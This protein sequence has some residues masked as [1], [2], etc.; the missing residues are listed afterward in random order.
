MCGN[1]PLLTGWFAHFATHFVV[2]HPYCIYSQC[3]VKVHLT[4]HSDLSWYTEIMHFLYNLFSPFFLTYK[5]V[6]ILEGLHE[7]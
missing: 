4:P 7:S 3:T 2:K 6:K 1:K 5:S